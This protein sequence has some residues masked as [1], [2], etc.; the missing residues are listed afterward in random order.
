M[1]QCRYNAVLTAVS[2]EE[3][4]HTDLRVLRLFPATVGVLLKEVFHQQ[5]GFYLKMFFFFFCISIPSFS[6]VLVYYL[7][8]I[9]WQLRLVFLL[10][11][12]MKMY[13]KVY[14]NQ[15]ESLYHKDRN[16]YTLINDPLFEHDFNF[17]DLRVNWKYA[18]TD[19]C[20]QHISTYIYTMCTSLIPSITQHNKNNVNCFKK[21]L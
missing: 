19:V 2:E 15:R 21:I 13:C 3:R 7:S 18:P 6:F 4:A 11:Q 12:S 16:T 5:L 1:E 9:H 10:H 14:S 8:M 17:F 20:I